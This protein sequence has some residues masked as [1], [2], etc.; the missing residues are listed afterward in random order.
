[1]TS[2]SAVT[3]GNSLHPSIPPPKAYLDGKSTVLEYSIITW[4]SLSI[5]ALPPICQSHSDP[6]SAV[7]ST[8]NTCDTIYYTIQA[9][10]GRLHVLRACE[11]TSLIHF[12]HRRA[13]STYLDA[14]LL[15][16]YDYPKTL[17]FPF[18]AEGFIIR[19][20]GIV[21]IYRYDRGIAQV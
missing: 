19:L 6:I 7:N 13:P 1:M 18:L 5:P 20:R 21:A 3:L 12:A 9:S 2:P 15:E 4:R 17:F 8:Y 14:I 16:Y 11:N 10:T